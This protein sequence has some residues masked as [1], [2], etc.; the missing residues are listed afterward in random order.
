M[1]TVFSMEEVLSLSEFGVYKRNEAG[2][3]EFFVNGK[4]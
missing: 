3:I 4:R 2:K 1:P